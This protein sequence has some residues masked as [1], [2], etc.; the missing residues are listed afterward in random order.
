MTRVQARTYRWDLEPIIG[1]SVAALADTI[2]E[3]GKSSCSMFEGMLHLPCT[4]AVPLMHSLTSF[5]AIKLCY[6]PP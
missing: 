4:H 1:A 3:P 6:E 2:G 5:L